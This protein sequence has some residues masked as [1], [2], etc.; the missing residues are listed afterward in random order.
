MKGNRDISYKDLS[1]Q[2]FTV[3]QL[4]IILSFQQRE[5][6]KARKSAKEEEYRQICLQSL[7]KIYEPSHEKTCPRSPM[8]WDLNQL[9]QLQRLA[10]KLKFHL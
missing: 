4:G 3:F 1:W 7:G 5:A 10:G 8:K 2:E 9:A 6:E